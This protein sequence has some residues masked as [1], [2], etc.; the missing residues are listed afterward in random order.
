MTRPEWLA[1]TIS[2]IGLDL[3]K[4]VFQVHGVDAHGKVVVTRQLRRAG[5]LGFFANLPRCLIGLEACATAHHWARAIGGLGH[6]V[7]LMPPQYVRPY[8]DAGEA[9]T[10]SLCC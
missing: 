8:V 9:I 2:T 7:R 5:V 10:N 4:S 6:D 3:G 1:M